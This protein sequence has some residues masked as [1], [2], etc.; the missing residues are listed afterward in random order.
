M[1][2]IDKA[3]NDWAW[4]KKGEPLGYYNGPDAAKLAWRAAVAW[5]QAEDV[6]AVQEVRSQRTPR[7]WQAACDAILAAIRGDEGGG[8]EQ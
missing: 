5:K 7:I 2:K 6:A 3:F 8:D 1:T 4:T